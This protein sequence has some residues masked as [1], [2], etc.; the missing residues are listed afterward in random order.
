M[1][2]KKAPQKSIDNISYFL[3]HGGILKNFRFPKISAP[4][5]NVYRPEF[6][7][8]MGCKIASVA[9]EVV[10]GEGKVAGAKA[11]YNKDG[12]PR[13][14]LTKATEALNT[15]AHWST[16]A[17]EA[18]HMIQ[19]WKKWRMSLLEMEVDAHFAQAL[20]LH[21]KG[22]AASSDD[23]NYFME[24]AVAF[25]ANDKRKFKSLCNPMFQAASAK[26][27]NVYEKLAIPQKLNGI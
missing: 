6:Y 24:A 7:A 18:T 4:A 22:A 10:L 25:A 21:Y 9:I 1:S 5:I 14:T 20:F 17:H 15:P 19:D 13:L 16:I 26:Y 12:T 2:T 3:Q 8:E 27:K 11:F 23:M